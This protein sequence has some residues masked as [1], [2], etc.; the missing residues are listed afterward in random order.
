M[1]TEEKE[2]EI[3]RRFKPSVSARQI[4]RVSGVSVD[5]VLR[6]Q[7]AHEIANK[8][9]SSMKEEIRNLFAEGI[10]DHQIGARLNLPGLHIRDF[11]RYDRLSGTRT[12]RCKECG[13]VVFLN[14]R[15]DCEHANRKRIRGH[16]SRDNVRTISDIVT[17]LLSLG[18]L[19]L[20][21]HPL[22]YHLTQR[23]EKVYQ[24]I[25]GTTK[26][27]NSVRPSKGIRTGDTADS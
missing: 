10:G 8:I 4:A 21:T 26:K 19:K 5:T 24:K 25:H 6:I 9:P 3:R 14:H 16:V 7:R 13:A 15:A 12:E 23:A 17:D 27:K 1:I 11:R 20:I 18:D 22:F 2:R